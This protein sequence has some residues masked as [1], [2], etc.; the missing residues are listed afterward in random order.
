MEKYLEFA[1]S[2]AKESA[3]IALKYFSFEVDST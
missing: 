3:E 2:I 1:K